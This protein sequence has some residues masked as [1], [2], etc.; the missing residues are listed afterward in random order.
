MSGPFTLEQASV[1]FGGPFCSS[2]VG[3]VEKVS[4]YSQWRM[5]RHLSKQDDEGQ[6]M[7]GMDGWIQ[8]NSQLFTFLLHVS[9]IMWVPHPL[10]SFPVPLAVLSPGAPC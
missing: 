3:L 8:M 6:S 4:G 1:I 5:I 10:H 7:N 2:P 9:V